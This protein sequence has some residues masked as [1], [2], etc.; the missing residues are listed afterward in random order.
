MKTKEELIKFLDNFGFDYDVNTDADVEFYCKW[1]HVP[2]KIKPQVSYTIK[3]LTVSFFFD[4]NDNFLGVG[5]GDEL[6]GFEE[7]NNSNDGKIKTTYPIRKIPYVPNAVRGLP[8]TLHP[9][10]VS[11]L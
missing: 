2:D 3:A 5:L 11:D 9:V 8:F 4:K 10:K 6:A 1:F 7:V